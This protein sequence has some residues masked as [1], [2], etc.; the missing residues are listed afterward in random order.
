MQLSFQDTDDWFSFPLT[1]ERSHSTSQ[2][3]QNYK[4]EEDD[5]DPVS[6]VWQT[7]F[8]FANEKYTLSY[9]L[10]VIA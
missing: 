2:I 7:G 4:F 5:D 8:S 9:K 1:R 6:I 10:T 3:L